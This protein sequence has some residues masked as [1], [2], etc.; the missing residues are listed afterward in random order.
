MV[1][2]ADGSSRGALDGHQIYWPGG[3][4]AQEETCMSSYA[5]LASILLCS[6]QYLRG[7][8]SPSPTPLPLL[9]VS[10]LPLSLPFP[11]PLRLPLR[12]RLPLTRLPARGLLFRLPTLRQ[13]GSPCVSPKNA[14]DISLFFLPHMPTLSFTPVSIFYRLSYSRISAFFSSYL[15]L[16]STSLHHT[17][18]YPGLFQQL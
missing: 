9:S 12:L 13:L 4:D 10:Q 7:T 16:S 17:Q 6:L 3:T 1:V 15:T 18:L 8:P 5:I 2:P 11:L 14:V